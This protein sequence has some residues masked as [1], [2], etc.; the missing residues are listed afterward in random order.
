MNGN[1]ESKISNIIVALKYKGGL[2]NSWLLRTRI[3]YTWGALILKILTL[4]LSRP[5]LIEVPYNHLHR[6][7]PG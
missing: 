6:Q 5:Q 4:N 7:I 3:L 2:R 1:Y